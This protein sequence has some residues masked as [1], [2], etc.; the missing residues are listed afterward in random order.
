MIDQLSRRQLLKGVAGAGL[1][2]AAGFRPRAAFAQTSA[3]GQVPTWKTETRQIAPNIYAY[4]QGGGPGMLNQGVS[5]AGFIAAGDNILVLD[6]LGAPIHAKNFIAAMH[7]AVPNKQFGRMVITHHHG[8]HIMGLPFFPQSMEIVWHEYCRKEMLAT[9]F[10]TPTWEK[11]E[12]WSEG[13]EPRKIVPPTT[14]IDDR[15]TYYYGNTE[16]QVITN[17]P[18]HTFGD[19]MIYLPQHKLLFAG[20]IAF[21]YV[22]PFCH[23]AHPTK[24]LEAVDKILAMDVDM[25]VPGHG[26]IGGKKELAEMAD[27]I[28]IFKSE[29]RKRYDDGVSAGKAA[30][31]IKLGKFDAWIGAQDRLVMNTVRFYHEFKGDLVPAQDVEGM[32]IATAEFNAIKGIKN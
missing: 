25:I 10:P 14:T 16:V 21:S 29:A 1:G 8:D 32:R 9:T 24:W 6:S 28:S 23:N 11:R 18:A 19:L 2:L 3:S 27:Y 4:V 22:A 20:D 7:K 31:S 15:T 26:P 5:N 13:G 30:A 12:G 17:A